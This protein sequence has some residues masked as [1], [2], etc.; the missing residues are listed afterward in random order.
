MLV[1]SFL[2]LIF[3]FQDYLGL[4]PALQIAEHISACRGPS[5]SNAEYALKLSVALERLGVV[6][7]HVS[8]VARH[9]MCM[10]HSI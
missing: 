5:G 4:A 6:D 7:A 1:A 3:F 2:F 10:G 9:L 8:A